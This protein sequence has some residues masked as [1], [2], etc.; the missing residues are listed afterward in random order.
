[1][2]VGN[3]VL[4]RHLNTSSLI[5]KWM[6]VQRYLIQQVSK[7][8]RKTSR[9]TP[10][11]KKCKETN[12]V[13]WKCLSLGIPN[14]TSWSTWCKSI[15]DGVLLKDCQINS[16]LIFHNADI[17]LGMNNERSLF[18]EL[19][20]KMNPFVPNDWELSTG[21]YLSLSDKRIVYEF[22][23]N[24]NE[25]LGDIISKTKILGECQTKK[26]FMSGIDFDIFYL[27]KET[28]RINKILNNN[29][30]VLLGQK[31]PV[32]RSFKRESQGAV[33]E[34]KAQDHFPQE[35]Q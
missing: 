10:D 20:K 2:D 12:D 32:R 25:F 35:E 18:C 14:Y 15:M 11:A 33:F 19:R 28:K 29:A 4:L 21:E 17:Y 24:L 9:H 31:G 27:K 7:K 22:L 30:C 13:L 26:S 5:K 3:E 16:C 8:K 6:D 1:M 34:Q 23:I